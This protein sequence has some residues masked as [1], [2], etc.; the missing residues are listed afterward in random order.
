MATRGRPRLSLS[1][2]L[3][4]GVDKLP[5]SR[6]RLRRWVAAAI[7]CDSR[8]TLRFVDEAE[9]RELNA[10]YRDRDY[11]TNVLTFRYDDGSPD[12]HADI[13]ICMPVVRGEARAQ[14]TDESAHLA[15]LVV[16]GVLHA[17]GYDHEDDADAARMQARESALLARFG[18]ADPWRDRG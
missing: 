11:A 2:Q 4:H 17:S 10:G 15:H 3:G 9:A 12:V 6:S 16:H 14:G 7:E 13:A 5:A 1:V 8:L 18:F